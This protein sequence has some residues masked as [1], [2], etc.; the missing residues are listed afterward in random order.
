MNQKYTTTTNED[1]IW[2]LL[3]VNDMLIHKHANLF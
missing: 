1:V 2:L 3:L